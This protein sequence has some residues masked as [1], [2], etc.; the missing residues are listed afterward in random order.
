MYLSPTQVVLP[1][2]LRGF[3][4]AVHR[5]ILTLI[6]ALRQLDGQV[7]S[8]DDAKA[9]GVR[10]G[11]HCIV[12]ADLTSI[13]KQLLTGLSLLEGCIPVIQLKPSLHHFVHHAEHT[14]MF[15]ALRWFWMYGFERYNKFV[16][17]NCRNTRYPRASVANALNL[18][19]AARYQDF[20]ANEFDAGVRQDILELQGHP[21]VYVPQD[22]EAQGLVFASGAG[23]REVE[24]GVVAFPR[25]LI[26][27]VM[28]HAGEGYMYP[29]LMCPSCHSPACIPP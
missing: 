27:G 8:Y 6:F 20:K 28:F 23:V 3:V 22:S 26:C 12:T 17:D 24:N 2:V 15:G 18:N 11:S 14:L 21:F 7:Y 10:P 29:S 19:A 5:A 13:H 4:P 16:K 9:L 25:A 1:T